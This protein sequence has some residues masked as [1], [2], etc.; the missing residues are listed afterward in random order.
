[1]F[2]RPPDLPRLRPRE[3]A[4]D[5]PYIGSSLHNDV[6]MW[7][8]S[9]LRSIERAG[10]VGWHVTGLLG[11]DIPWDNGE[12]DHFFADLTIYPTAVDPAAETIDLSHAGPPLFV[13]EIADID[14]AREMAADA[15]LTDAKAALYAAI[16]VR[17]YLVYDL[18]IAR[19]GRGSPIWARRARDGRAVVTGGWDAWQPNERGVWASETSGLAFSPAGEDDRVSLRVWGLDGKPYLTAAEYFDGVRHRAE[20]ERAAVA[21]AKLTLLRARYKR[22]L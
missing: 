15:D 14:G 20:E 7:L 21:E 6:M 5:R 18:E 11:M 1:M 10:H 9:L 16:G 17:E 13:L 22:D 19:H 3:M 12:I 4:G 2:H 8:F